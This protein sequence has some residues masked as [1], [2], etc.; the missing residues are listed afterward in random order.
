MVSTPGEITDNSLSFLMTS[1][2]VKKPSARK[3]LCIFTNT[4]DVKNKTEKRRVGD[5]ESKHRSM[6][7]GNILWTKKTKQ[8][9]YSKINE[10]IKHNLY[11]W[12]TRHPQNIQSPISNDYLKV[13]LMIRQNLNSFQIFYFKCT[14]E[15]C[16][17]AL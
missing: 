12:I 17:I 4:F 7:V 3:S 9:G 15:N 10:H 16:I 8:K 11:V 6:K 13:F 14:L 5:K 1:T 2:P